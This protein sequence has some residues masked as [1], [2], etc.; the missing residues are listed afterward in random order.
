MSSDGWS[1][2]R[3]KG[4]V[5]EVLSTKCELNSWGCSQVQFILRGSDPRADE[6]LNNCLHASPR[7]SSPP[8]PSLAQCALDP[9]RLPAFLCLP[10]HLQRLLPLV[11]RWRG[12]HSRWRPLPN[13]LHAQ[14]LRV[15]ARHHASNTR[16]Y[17][18]NRS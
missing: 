11:C 12:R 9:Y 7:I 14:D 3:T 4:E 8:T 5:M 18:E 13:T 16:S 15:L 17:Q 6:L 2:R 1:R 10:R